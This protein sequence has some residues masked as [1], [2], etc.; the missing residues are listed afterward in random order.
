MNRTRNT[1][2]ATVLILSIFGNFVAENMLYKFKP[3][4]RE[5]DAP[6]FCVIGSFVCGLF[7]ERLGV[8]FEFHDRNLTV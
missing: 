2:S 7:Q 4:C 1:V 5:N 8:G 3:G 6:V